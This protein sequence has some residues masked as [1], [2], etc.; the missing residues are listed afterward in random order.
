MLHGSEMDQDKSRRLHQFADHAFLIPSQDRCFTVQRQALH[1][2]FGNSDRKS[3]CL[4]PV[5]ACKGFIFLLL[6]KQNFEGIAFKAKS[7]HIIFADLISIV[8]QCESLTVLSQI[9]V[10]GRALRHIRQTGFR[11]GTFF[12]SDHGCT[13]R[14]NLLRPGVAL[15]NPASGPSGCP[16]FR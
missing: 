1:R 13:G 10:T 12:C 4:H 11:T 6:L 2:G 7:A 14:R 3:T 9:P 15:A 16:V 8:L 5:F